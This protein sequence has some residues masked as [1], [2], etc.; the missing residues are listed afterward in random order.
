MG[1]GGNYV[2]CLVIVVAFMG[3]GGAKGWGGR[4][5]EVFK[6]SYR[7]ESHK[8]GVNIYGGELTPLD[9]MH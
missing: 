2:C 7:E 1:V 6:S 5:G 3:L 4:R 8:S 9:I